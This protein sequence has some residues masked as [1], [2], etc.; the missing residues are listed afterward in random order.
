MKDDEIIKRNL[1]LM[2]DFMK[3]AFDKPGILD[4]IPRDAQL[5][6]LPINDPELYKENMKTLNR[7]KKD[8]QTYVAFKIESVMPRVELFEAHD[9]DESVV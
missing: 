1:D 9:L 7:L 2:S 4:V 3:Y 8:K 6:L 5:I